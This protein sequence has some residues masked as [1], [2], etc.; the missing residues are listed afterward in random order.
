MLVGAC[1]SKSKSSS[2]GCIWFNVSSLL[3]CTIFRS[4]KASEF[5]KSKSLYIGGEL[6]IFPSPR[7]YIDIEGEI[8]IFS[9][10]RVYIYIRVY[11]CQ[12]P[13]FFQFPRSFSQGVGL[14]SKS[15]S[16]ANVPCP[17]RAWVNQKVS[18]DKGGWSI[19]CLGVDMVLWSDERAQR[20]NKNV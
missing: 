7:A 6:W 8:G 3:W 11:I 1:V 13:E 5:F 4:S 14:L 17:F 16:E 18:V 20:G 12:N 19:D 15:D 9:S 10:P 2:E